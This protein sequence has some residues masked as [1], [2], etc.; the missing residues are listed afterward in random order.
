MTNTK[1]EHVIPK[2]NLWAVRREESGRVSK[3][4]RTQKEASDYAGIVAFNDGGSVIIH[5]HN[6][7]FKSFKHG[8][9]PDLK[10]HR[11]ASIITGTREIIHPIINNID[12]VIE[13]RMNN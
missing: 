9:N 6:G 13:T 11:I 7:Q 3:I 12:P 8:S 5:K 10:I 2:N 4:F 1:N